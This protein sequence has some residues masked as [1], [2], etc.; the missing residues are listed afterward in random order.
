MSVFLALSVGEDPAVVLVREGRLVAAIRESWLV[1]DAAAGFPSAA[2]DAVLDLAGLRASQVS[3]GVVTGLVARGAGGR[4][5]LSRARGLL[6]SARAVPGAGARVR[7]GV[8]RREALGREGLPAAL[9]RSRLPAAGWSEVAPEASR[10]ALARRAA[11]AL[12]H[13]AGLALGAAFVHLPHLLLPDGPALWGPGFDD[14]AAYRALSNAELPRA[15][16]ENPEAFARA[17]L[18]GGGSVVWASGPAAFLEVPL[19][20]RVRFRPG[21]AAPP[22]GWCG[23]DVLDVG[24]P[25]LLVGPDGFAVVTPSDAV[26]AFRHHAADALVLGDYSVR[27]GLRPGSGAAP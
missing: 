8:A 3:G 5:L 22:P 27:A 13:A 7:A 12:P 16:T 9:A 14:L 18:A 24:V 20:P 4:G 2:V 15:R 10:V 11:W 25:E 1:R 6:D 17:V 19:G 21:R 23:P 26:R